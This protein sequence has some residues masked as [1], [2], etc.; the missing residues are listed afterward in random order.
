MQIH[1]ASG[2]APDSRGL[3]GRQS[4]LQGVVSALVMGGVLVGIPAATWYFGA[5]WLFW[6]VSGGLALL[7]VP[8]IVADAAARFRRTNW[9]LWLDPDGI[10]INLRSYQA[11][12]DGDPPTLVRLRYDEIASAAKRVE[13]YLLPGSKGGSVR[14]REQ[15][16]DLRLNQPGTKELRVALE[17]ER[18][19]LGKGRT[20]AGGIT[21][22]TRACLYPVSAPEDDLVRILWRSGHGHHASPSLAAVLRELEGHGVPIGE[23][24]QLD[25]GRLDGLSDAE[26][27]DLVRHLAGSG[28]GLAAAKLLQERCGLTTTEARREIDAITGKQPPP[29]D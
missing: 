19:H 14:H 27:S 7:I 9:L 25:R 26:L 4:R 23:P 18:N 5:H 15:S 24:T 3:V 29:Q 1:P 16:I 8:L 21:V 17:N 2:V 22:T 10:W 28:G 13:T 20:Y 12:R 6:I 11:A